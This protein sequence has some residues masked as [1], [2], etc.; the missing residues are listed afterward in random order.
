MKATERAELRARAET[1]Q[2]AYPGEEDG[3]SP[4]LVLQLLDA[5]EAAEAAYERLRA[6]LV[7][8]HL[9]VN[10]CACLVP[11]QEWEPYTTLMRMIDSAIT[12]T[13]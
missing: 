13:P 12:V 4:D 5:L 3:V 7:E 8:A 9:F 6:V 2:R 11:V 10:E 1:A